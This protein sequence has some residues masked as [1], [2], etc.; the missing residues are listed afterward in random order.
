MTFWRKSGAAFVV[1]GCAVVGMGAAPA[2]A[3]VPQPYY[4]SVN[5]TCWNYDPPASNVKHKVPSYGQVK[6]GKGYLQVRD[7]G[8]AVRTM[9]QRINKVGIPAPTSGVFDTTTLKALC[10][11][12]DKFGMNAS[13]KLTRSGAIKL[14]ALAHKAKIPSACTKKKQK[15][16]ICVDKTMKVLRY[17]EHGRLVLREDARFGGV[18]NRT[19]EGNFKVFNK[20]YDDFSALYQMPM[21]MSLYFSGGQAI[22]FSRY[23]RA[24]GYNG[25]SHGCVNVRDWNTQKWL[26]KRVPIGTPVK[27][28]RS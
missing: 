16:I 23:F 21:D 6:A 12:Q 28:Y 15:R 25:A 24:D 3:S 13:G 7:R 2:S 10:N 26:Y 5:S 19:R 27:I 17:F 22:H 4:P 18:G 9:Q 11:L 8:A 1:A 14:D 20:V